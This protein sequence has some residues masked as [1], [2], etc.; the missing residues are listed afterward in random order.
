MDSVKKDAA[1][2]AL[3]S[4]FLRGTTIAPTFVK[5]EAL[6]AQS[7][8]QAQNIVLQPKKSEKTR[9]MIQLPDGTFAEETKEQRRA[10]RKA[11]KEAESTIKQQKDAIAAKSGAQMHRP[12]TD[13]P[14]SADAGNNS[15]RELPIDDPEEVLPPSKRRKK[16]R[17]AADE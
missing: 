10:R 17:P 1:K 14:W 15:K 3:Y 11:K 9:R 7:A 6:P 12:A 4:A 13:A 8:P 16:V 5:D 2:A